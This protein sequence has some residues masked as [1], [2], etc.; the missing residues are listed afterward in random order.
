[1]KSPAAREYQQSRRAATTEA[2]RQ[3]II[4][5]AASLFLSSWYDEI[6]LRQ[7]A[8]EAGVALQTVVN[9]FETKA[10]LA[11]AVA[12]HIGSGID[13]ARSAVAAGDAEGG[14]AMLVDEYERIGDGIVRAL[15]LEGRIPEMSGLLAIGRGVHRDWIERVFAAALP[16][17]GQPDRDRRIALFVTAT[18]VLTWKLLRRDQGLSR[19]DTELAMRE[20]VTALIGDRRS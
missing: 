1:M 7:I 18:D 11:T 15:S 14:V 19:A 13:E 16:A 9:H 20:L 4:E 12:P 6:S 2:T 17:S 10:N 8:R 3:R 5:T